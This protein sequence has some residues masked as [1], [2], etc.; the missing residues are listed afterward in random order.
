M[1]PWSNYSVTGWREKWQMHDRT[2]GFPQITWGAVWHKL[3]LCQYNVYTW[4]SWIWDNTPAALHHVSWE[5]KRLLLC[6][7]GRILICT[8]PLFILWQ[9]VHIF[10]YI[11][12][13]LCTCMCH[14]MALTLWPLPSKHEKRYVGCSCCAPSEN[15]IR[16]VLR[17]KKQFRKC[18]TQWLNFR[19]STTFCCYLLGKEYYFGQSL[20]NLRIY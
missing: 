14:L 17:K 12:V 1:L 16:S 2:D 11:I 20:F 13:T 5:S 7:C 9:T 10:S 4:P 3:G 15:T 19:T 8:I 6:L 18:Y